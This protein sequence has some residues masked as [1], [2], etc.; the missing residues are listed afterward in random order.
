MPL[1]TPAPILS[2]VPGSFAHGVF[3][4][5]HP[6]LVERVLDA[7]PFG[8]CERAAIERLLVE[9]TSGVLEPLTENTA[10]RDRWRV[11]G[12]GLYG[13]PWGEAPFLWAE[14]FFYRKLLEATGYFGTGAWRGIDV[15]A[16]FK[17][18][19]LTGKTV[20]DQLST[21]AAHT[22]SAVEDRRDRLLTSALWGNRADLGFQLTSAPISTGSSRVL[23]DDSAVL[24]SVLDAAANPAVSLIADNAAGEL[25]PDLVL[26]DHLLTTGLAAQVVIWV[27]P[28]PYYVSDATMSDVVDTIGFL[29]T[30]PH[31]AAAAIGQ[32]LHGAMAAGDL[33]VR[34]HDFFCAPLPFTAMPGDLAS[35][36]RDTAITVLKGDLNYRRLVGDLHWPATTPF[37]ETANY[38]PSPLIAARTLKSDVV[39]GL[40]AAQVDE[41]DAA[42]S[43]WRTSG[44]HAVIQA[45]SP[46]A[47]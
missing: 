1:S 32:R 33:K 12:A 35:E 26:V 20:E 6:K 46:A 13:R 16:S 9:S 24:W 30:S 27:K 28:H 25:V 15:F 19:E 29:R 34:T 4:E 18:A 5:R 31:R 42:E 39:V 7:V 21:V 45:W 23:V 40:T 43:Q 37:A 44:E 38:F 22:G 47:R 14:S 41:L 10:D 2:G 11:W 36:F 3:V 8:P 17:N